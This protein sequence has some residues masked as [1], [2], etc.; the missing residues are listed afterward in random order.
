MIAGGVGLCLIGLNMRTGSPTVGTF[1]ILF[2][3]AVLAAGIYK[4]NNRAMEYSLTLRGINYGN[5]HLK[6][7]PWTEISAMKKISF[8]GGIYILLK[9]ENISRYDSGLSHDER[10]LPAGA[11]NVGINSLSIRLAG[12]DSNPEEIAKFIQQRINSNPE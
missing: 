2:A 6:M 4:L 8:N 7:V 12:T 11:E 5:T 10:L 3:L 9:I 1:T